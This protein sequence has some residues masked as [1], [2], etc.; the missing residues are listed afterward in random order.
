MQTRYLQLPLAAALALLSGCVAVSRREGAANVEQLLQPRLSTPF[1]WR[2]D[3]SA[4]VIDA[5]AAELLAQPLTPLSAFQLAQLRNPA[6]ASHYAEL[7]IAQAAVVEASRLG[8]PSFS[9]AS[10]KDQG[11]AEITTGV[12]LPLSDLLMLSSRRQFAAGE[13]ERSQLLI[14]QALFD[15]AA[16]AASDWYA[17]AGAEQVAA[18]RA[19][20]A[21]AADASAELAGRFHDAGN[22]SALQ[23][24]LEQAAASQARIAATAAR[25]EARRARLALNARMGLSGAEAARWQLDLP[26]L[27]PVQ[28]ED[29]AAGLLALAQQQRLD[30]SAARREVELL[31]QA[32]H[33]AR[34]WRLL[35]NVEVG[36]EREKDSDGSRRRGPTL[37][38][39]IP[40]FNQGQ[41]AIARAEAQLEQGRAS[42]AQLQHGVDNAVRL[43]VEQVA[44]QRAIV[45]D[46]R[47]ALVPQ[48]EAVV[49]RELERFNYMLIGAFELLL[50]RQQEYDAYQGYLL[51][52]RDYWQARVAL[53]RAVGA[54]LPS[55]AAAHTR[56][57]GVEAVLQ[58]AAAAGHG[59]HGGHGDHGN[60]GQAAGAA[61]D[62]GDPGQHPDRASGDGHEDHNCHGDHRTQPTP[63]NPPRTPAGHVGNAGANTGSG[64]EKRTGRDNGNPGRNSEDAEQGRQT[65]QPTDDHSQHPNHG[66]H[67]AAQPPHGAQ[68]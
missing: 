50:A 13:Y 15:L 42:L 40:L 61:Q 27:A 14:A 17:A 65:P 56:A 22:I 54:E 32:L 68:P 36:Y 11:P 12:S 63:A 29:E 18:M 33:L 55:S 52:V 24:K 23:L 25:A 58:P 49:Q 47:D 5:R 48:R 21:E 34:R 19:A 41:A 1:Q 38:L 35:G 16:D 6:I 45:A 46:Y 53:A 37:A 2:T 66:D 20:V 30:L 10:I 28:N 26:L 44:A 39:A 9:F 60:H 51:A 59:G 43:G 31:D 62:H 8:N 64:H 67:H 7:G 3:P 57:L 4:T